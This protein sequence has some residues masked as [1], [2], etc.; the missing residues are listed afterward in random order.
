M[1]LKVCINLYFITSLLDHP[2]AYAILFDQNKINQTIH[3]IIWLVSRESVSF[4]LHTKETLIILA[5]GLD[6]MMFHGVS[7]L[8]EM[9]MGQSVNCIVSITKVS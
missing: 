4:R 8:K 1:N 2:L 9:K 3:V 6:I 5:Q 7:Q